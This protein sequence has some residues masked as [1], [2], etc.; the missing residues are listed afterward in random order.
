[1]TETPQPRQRPI[2]SGFGSPG[3]PPRENEDMPLDDL[4][5][6]NTA[7]AD[8][9]HHATLNDSSSPAEL[10]SAEKFSTL[11]SATKSSRARKRGSE[12]STVP[13]RKPERLNGTLKLLTPAEVADLTGI[14]VETL[15]QWRSQKRGIPYIKISRNCVRYR[16]SDVD[17][18]VHARIVR[19]EV[20]EL[21]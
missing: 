5:I 20:G 6:R 2:G 17:L 11:A 16:V 1:M 19:L 15:A 8:A 12:K 10:K 7:A 21:R 9:P 14:S 18:W 4:A 13:A 3:P